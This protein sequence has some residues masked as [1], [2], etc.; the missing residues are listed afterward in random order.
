M[1]GRYFAVCVRVYVRFQLYITI[2]ISLG[3]SDTRFC[4]TR[5]VFYKIIRKFN[6]RKFWGYPR[7]DRILVILKKFVKFSIDI[8]QLQTNLCF[9]I[10]KRETFCRVIGFNQDCSTRI[11]KIVKRNKTWG[12][13]ILFTFICADYTFL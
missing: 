7:C 13:Y 1:R 10:F 4:F 9:N 11:A 12:V 5:K 3:G 2:M 8:L 6:L